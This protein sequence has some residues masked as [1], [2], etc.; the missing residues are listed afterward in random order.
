MF[1]LFMM[2]L[3]NLMTIFEH[4]Y[5]TIPV[6]NSNE[7]EEIKTHYMYLGKL[8]INV[9]SKVTS[10]MKEELNK[11]YFHLLEKRKLGEKA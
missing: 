1:G 8:M 5:L 10:L 7:E 4:K 6:V 9:L 2:K 3:N 11:F